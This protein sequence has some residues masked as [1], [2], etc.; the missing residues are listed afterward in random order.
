[1]PFQVVAGTGWAQRL[2]R[3]EFLIVG[4]ACR[5]RIMRK[6]LVDH[7][8]GTR[9]SIHSAGS[10]HERWGMLAE[11]LFDSGLRFKLRHVNPVDGRSRFTDR[12]DVLFRHLQG[13][14]NAGVGPGW[15]M[16]GRHRL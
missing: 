3:L 6:L 10:A 5:R 7:A 2:W 12:L 11:P 9:G 15:A 13:F 4:Y 14:R 8:F 1:M 16:G